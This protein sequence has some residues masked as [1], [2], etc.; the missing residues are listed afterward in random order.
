MDI[1]PDEPIKISFGQTLEDPQPTNPK[2]MGTEEQGTFEMRT[3]ETEVIKFNHNARQ[4]LKKIPKLVKNRRFKRLQ[5]LIE[6]PEYFSENDIRRRAP[7]L[8]HMYVGR[9]IRGGNNPE[10]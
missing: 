3:F 7:I 9:F 1:E 4:S 8:Y 10:I 5:E 2:T 6:D